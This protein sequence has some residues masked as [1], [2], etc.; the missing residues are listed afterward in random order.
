VQ[1]P[2][3]TYRYI[4]PKDVAGPTFE[5]LSREFNT[6]TTAANITQTLQ[7]IPKDKVFVLTNITAQLSPG[8]TQSVVRMRIQ[9]FTGA[10][11]TFDIFALNPLGSADEEHIGVW[12]GSVYL[13]GRGENLDTV[14]M[15]ANFS[16]GVNANGATFA[17]H[18]IVI[19]RGNSSAF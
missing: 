13:P 18:G 8:A 11:A 15:I 16:A 14:A 9:G 12:Q 3:I 6:A 19:P 1:A 7:G 17:L 10:G 2:G 5:I 4:Y